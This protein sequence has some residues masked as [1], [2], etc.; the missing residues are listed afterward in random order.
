MVCRTA[1]I[2]HCKQNS[3]LDLRAPGNLPVTFSQLAKKQKADQLPAVTLNEIPIS[4]I[5]IKVKNSW[6]E[7]GLF[8]SKFFLN[9]THRASVKAPSLKQA[10]VSKNTSFR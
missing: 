5:K 4:K 7:R 1:A 8:S 9:Q 10:K 2:Q 3:I 6:Q